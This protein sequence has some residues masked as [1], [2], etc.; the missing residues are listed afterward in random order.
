MS[1]DDLLAEIKQ[2]IPEDKFDIFSEQIEVAIELYEDIDD[3]KRVQKELQE[4]AR[5]SKKVNYTLV[6][7]IKKVSP[8]TIRFLERFLPLPSHPNIDSFEELTLYANDI[9]RRITRGSSL[10]DGAPYNFP[11]GAHRMGRPRSHR[12]N[13]LV[14]FVAA[15][16][17]AATG[18]V[19]RR[20]WDV[21]GKLPIHSI[22]AATFHELKISA[23]VDEAIR[24]LKLEDAF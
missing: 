8:T 10:T 5:L 11:S 1:Q 13:V 22:L 3:P 15:A 4:L 23:S 6:N 18:N 20:K 19:I 9:R 12:V 7:V 24:R 17:V 14:S 2:F 16:Y 21:D